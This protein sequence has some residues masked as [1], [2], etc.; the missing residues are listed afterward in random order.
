MKTVEL[1]RT[2]LFLPTWIGTAWLL[3]AHAGWGWAG[4]AGLGLV[5]AI[6]ICL[7]ATLIHDRLS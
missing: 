1:L 4:S 2:V 3:H 6:V 7:V 5:A